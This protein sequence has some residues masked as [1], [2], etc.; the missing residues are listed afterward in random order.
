MTK[1]KTEKT[2][3][4]EKLQVEK[5]A[6]TRLSH[7]QWHKVAVYLVQCVDPDSTHIS[8]TPADLCALVKQDCELLTNPNQLREMLKQ[9]EI[10]HR[11]DRPGA[12]D[13]I[14]L[15]HQVSTLAEQLV[16]ITDQVGKLLQGIGGNGTTRTETTCDQLDNIETV[17]ESQAKDIE[18]VKQVLNQHAQR[19][20]NAAAAQVPADDLNQD[21]QAGI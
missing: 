10:T 17:L 11:L 13:V 6:S 1:A 9:L 4:A 20:G 19:L 18:K 5:P 15:S 12:A 2:E 14:A 3:K 21:Q 8:A 7:A 16:A